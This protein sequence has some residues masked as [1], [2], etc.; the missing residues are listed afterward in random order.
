MSTRSPPAAAPGT[1]DAGSGAASAALGD[2]SS[3]GAAPA[4]GAAPAALEAAPAAAGTSSAGCARGRQ[5]ITTVSTA[6][7]GATLPPAVLA[8]GRPEARPLRP[9][10]AARAS[11]PAV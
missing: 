7:E 11:E 8:A 4:P 3:A 9:P 10:A 5:S 1:G 2:T 6:G